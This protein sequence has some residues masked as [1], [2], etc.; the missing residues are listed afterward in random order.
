MSETLG[1]D[2]ALEDLLKGELFS[3]EHAAKR[4][5]SLPLLWQLARQC[6]EALPA[7]DAYW[8]QFDLPRVMPADYFQ[9]PLLAVCLF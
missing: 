2:Q 9:L 3:R 6:A 4:A 5:T 7:F 1:I 8:R